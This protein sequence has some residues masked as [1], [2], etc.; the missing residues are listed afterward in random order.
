[1]SNCGHAHPRR[2]DLRC[3]LPGGEDHPDHTDGEE[4]WADPAL[5][6]QADRRQRRGRGIDFARRAAAAAEPARRSR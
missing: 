2:P 3:I 4:V 1:V 6:E 5:A